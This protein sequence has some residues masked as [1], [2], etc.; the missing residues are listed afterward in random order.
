MDDERVQGQVG[1]AVG[2]R[3]V[4]RDAAAGDEHALT[5]LPHLHQELEVL[6]ERRAVLVEIIVLTDVVGGRSDD[7]LD[8][9]VV[10]LFHRPRVAAINPVEFH[11]VG[12]LTTKAQRHEEK[13]N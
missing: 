12:R 8:R 13:W 6:V 9:V 5:L 7:E 1:V 3:D 4:D 10:Q 11:R 2:V